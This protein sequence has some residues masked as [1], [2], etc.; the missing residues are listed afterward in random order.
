M[1][2]VV[3]HS[4]LAIKNTIHNYW[5]EGDAIY[6]GSHYPA[7]L[8]HLDLGVDIFFCISGFIMYMLIEKLSPNAESSLR[9][10]L[11]RAIRI[12]PPYWFFSILVVIAFLLSKGSF[13]VGQ[14]SGD[15]S[16][17]SFRFLTSILLLPQPQSP[18]LGVGW[19]LVHESLFYFVCGL[20]VI[21]GLNR[22]LPEVLAAVSI[23]AVILAVLNIPIL[24]GY[25]FSTFYIEFL[26]GA[27]AYKLYKTN[28]I[29][30]FPILTILFGG[31]CYL[32]VCYILDFQ[33]VHNITF[34]TRQLGGGL[35]GFLLISGVIGADK[36]YS[37]STTILG[38]LLMRIGDASYTLY[39]M[40]WFVLSIMGKIIGLVP[41]VPLL[42]V[43]IWHLLSI[44]T[45]IAFA[46]FLA[47]RIELPFHRWLL[48]RVKSYW[49]SDRQTAR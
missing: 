15:L 10:L 43:A 38:S 23:V 5:L 44:A 48:Q 26:F 42:V 39:L 49:R 12:F 24:F 2:V 27:L 14:L 19:T 32:S 29:T 3:W 31:V 25:A 17:D 7:F 22:R 41:G 36:K 33:I 46:V 6:R 30:T 45:A 18:I 21:A 40:H 11:N 16:V 13:N 34:F 47:E 4:H 9:F 20:L 8:N 1:M 37:I 35:V 28:R